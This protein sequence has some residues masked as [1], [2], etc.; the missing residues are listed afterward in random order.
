MDGVGSYGA[1]RTG[2]TVDPITFAKQPQTILRVLSWIFSLVVFASIIN[3]GYVNTGSERLNCVFNKN[4]YACH[5]GEVVGLASLLQCTLFF[6]VDYKFSSISS[7]KE[8]KK[9][10]ALDVGISGFGTFLYLVSFFFL[11]HQWY[12]TNTDDV[13]LNQGAAAARAAIVFSFVSIL[14]WAGLTVCAVQ[15]YL[16]G[17]DVTL[18][19]TEH[20]DG[21]GTEAVEPGRVSSF[22]E[23]STAPTNQFPVC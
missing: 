17:T 2:S 11:T 10:V 4:L 14:T 16:L 22:P 13:P 5:Y 6:L 8:R 19:T 23:N 3:E 18:F 12:R 15:R 9:I 20:M 21:G 1:G 7:V